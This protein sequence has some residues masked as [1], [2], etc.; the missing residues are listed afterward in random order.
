MISAENQGNFAGFEGPQD[1]FRALGAG[2]RNL[3]EI[4]RVGGAFLL[5]FR[6]GDGDIASILDDVANGFEARFESSD[7]DGGWAHVDAAPR[8]AE[9]EG[10][11]DDADLLGGDGTEGR[12]GSWR[13]F[14]WLLS[15]SPKRSTEEIYRLQITRLR[16]SKRLYG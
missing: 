12:V 8:L 3:L 15:M 13:H 10:D 2:G 16:H 5:L 6:N 11:S 4:L 7:A 9:V 1:Q 14:R